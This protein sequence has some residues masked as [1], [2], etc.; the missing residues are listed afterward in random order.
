MLMLNATQYQTSSFKVFKV[1]SYFIFSK[2]IEYYFILCCKLLSKNILPNT[3][4]V[5]RDR[6]YK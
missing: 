6:K 4:Y 3:D 1:V 2:K 5:F